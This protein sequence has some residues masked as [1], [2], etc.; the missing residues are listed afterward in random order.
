[1][2]TIEILLQA[3][4][5]GACNVSKLEV[6]A[7]TFGTYLGGRTGQ[8]DIDGSLL[9]GL[10]EFNFHF[11]WRERYQYNFVAHNHLRFLLR[12]LPNDLKSLTLSSDGIT[13][14]TNLD[15]RTISYN[16]FEGLRHTVLHAIQFRALASI[17]LGKM[18]FYQNDLLRFLSAHRGSLKR[19]TLDG[20]YVHGEWDQV[21]SCIAETFSL[22]H[23]KLSKAQ[24]VVGN[25]RTPRIAPSVRFVSRYSKDC[26]LKSKGQ[27]CQDLNMFIELQKVEVLA[28]E[29]KKRG[30]PR[31]EE[32]RRSA[33]IAKNKASKI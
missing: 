23:F 26:E 33:R 13:L 19:L 17:H 28:K 11:Q 12:R 29:A 27:V 31:L 9:L 2:S 20:V 25:P 3:A 32:P 24:T 8:H 21:L 7:N 18:V 14:E 30:P 16:L 15:P 6:G 1:M 22:E 5:A 4:K 10:Q